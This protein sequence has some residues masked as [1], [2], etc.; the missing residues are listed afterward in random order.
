MTDVITI[1]SISNNSCRI[2]KKAGMEV[3]LSEMLSISA[4][5]RSPALW[6]PSQIHQTHRR[7]FIGR[8]HRMKTSKKT[9]L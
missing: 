3:L 6:C 4:L 7:S 1:S 9:T 2:A 5:L 8:L